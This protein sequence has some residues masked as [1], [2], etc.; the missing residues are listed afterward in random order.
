[1]VVYLCCGLIASLAQIAATPDS[2]IPT[3]GASGAIA[4][5]LGMY[6]I[7]FPHNGI[8]VLFLRFIVIMPAAAVIGMWI[9]LQ[10][11]QG[12]GSFAQLGKVGGIAYLAHVGGA[13][14]GIFA[15]FLFLKDAR[16]LGQPTLFDR[17]R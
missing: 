14:T 15:A 4:G 10:L 3:L 2:Y 8:R 17:V 1:M 12:V 7:W 6:L 16:R 9:A 5:V 13:V 11:W